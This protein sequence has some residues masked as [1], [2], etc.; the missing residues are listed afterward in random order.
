MVLRCSRDYLRPIRA[1]AA[2]DLIG[3]SEEIEIEI[4]SEDEYLAREFGW[5]VRKLIEKEDDLRTVARIQ[6][7]A[8]HEPVFV[9]NDFFFYF[10][11]VFLLFLFLFLFLG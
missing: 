4:E 2:E 1:A 7:E 3:I 8:F 5:K 11:Q 10:F 9:F 6:A